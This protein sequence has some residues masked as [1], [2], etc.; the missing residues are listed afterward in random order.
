MS[1]IV[2][3]QA[4]QGDTATPHPID[5]LVREKAQ[6]QAEVGLLR[7]VSMLAYGALKALGSCPEV[8]TRL[9]SALFPPSIS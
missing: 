9:E 7:E 1:M 6:L 8:C 4:D 2:P 5:T 3:E